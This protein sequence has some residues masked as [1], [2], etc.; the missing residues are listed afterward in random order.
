MR[1]NYRCF[2][3]MIFLLSFL[4]AS[5]QELK[6]QALL[7]K[8]ELK[9]NADAVLRLEDCNVIVN[10]RDEMRINYRRI[11]TVLNSDGDDD[12]G[13]YLSYDKN[14]KIK[15]IQAV[16]F[17]AFGKEIKKAKKKDFKDVSAVSG[18]TLYSD[19]RVLYLDYTPVSYPYTVEFTYEYDSSNTAFLPR[20]YPLEGYNLSVEESS[21]KITDLANLSLRHKEKNFEKYP[22]IENLSSGTTL[23]YLVN[24]IPAL[25][26]E[27]YS[28]SLS[29]IA[30][31]VLFSLSKFHLEGVD[32][33]ATD[34]KSFGKWIYDDL[35]ATRDALPEST[36]NEIRTL[37]TGI[38]DPLEK[39]KIVYKYMQDRTRYISV[40]VGIG[41]WEPIDATTVDAAKYGDCK[42]LTNYTKA[43]L[44]AAG[45]ES[46]YTV[47]YAGRTPIGLEEDFASLQGNHVILNL[48]SEN[49]DIWLE[50]TSQIHPFGL[51]GDFTD[52]RNVLVVTPDGGIL[53]RT[54]VY[55]TADN[56][57]ITK[58]E[59]ILQENG[60]IDALVEISTFGVQYDNHFYR[61][62]DSKE[63][64]DKYYKNYWKNVND[65]SIQN[66]EF[67]NNRDDIRFTEK[68]ALSASKYASLA[69]NRL[70]FEPNIFNNR[71]E[72]P[73]RYKE[74]HLPFEI[75]RG[76]GYEDE[77]TIR[78]PEGYKIEAIPQNA[79]IRSKFGTYEVS[80]VDN[81]N[82]TITYQRKVTF[83]NG[84][85]NESEY[86]NYRDF[87]KD[88]TKNDNSK[89]VL[90]KQ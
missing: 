12:I 83:L 88:V 51:L 43:L 75:D 58:S 21:I 49:G 78:M 39:A 30:P 15:N 70:I 25:K 54:P 24:D 63:D 23:A 6:Y 1:K 11:V 89:I 90:I 35:I 74:R 26:P 55:S 34:W 72:V 40:Q 45:V 80:Y 46:Y 2:F 29:K 84:A 4:N 47:V 38:N 16:I 36:V 18:G 27:S 60:A 79:T 73:R 13:T 44:K 66:Y 31:V 7:I 37:V 57:Q 3:V 62:N 65:I 67:E 85:F 52:D 5:G 77:F 28:P 14:V 81:K 19:S 82:S 17:N 10:A 20:W 61:E 68:V 22:Q 87:I 76:Y 9:N 33:E 48:P 8:E 69:G 41:G 50:C 53:K 71:L 42:G 56:R 64:I 86:E 59:I 32:G